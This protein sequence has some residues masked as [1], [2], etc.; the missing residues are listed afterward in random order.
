MV[1]PLHR[2]RRQKRRCGIPQHLVQGL[3][4]ALAVLCWIPETVLPRLTINKAGDGCLAQSQ[5]PSAEEGNKE[6]YI[7]TQRTC[8]HKS[9]GLLSLQT[10]WGADV[11]RT[12]AGQK[13]FAV[14]V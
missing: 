6:Q 12:I 8:Q 5:H 7:G 3:A 11:M 9:K 4:S 2:D 14:G 10:F 1:N 13:A